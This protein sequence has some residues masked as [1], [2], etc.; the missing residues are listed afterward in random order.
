MFNRR[1][2]QN[3]SVYHGTL[4]C[5]TEMRARSDCLGDDVLSI[6]FQNLNV[7]DLL[8][9]EK[10]CKKWSYAFESSVLG[11]RF[12]Q[13]MKKSSA[14]W[15]RA[16]HKMAMDET[17]LKPEDYK[18][19]C[20]FI[21]H[22]IQQVDDNW[23]KGKFKLTSCPNPNFLNRRFAIGEDFITACDEK[24]QQT[25]IFEK[26][27]MELK[28]K[29][30]PDTSEYQILD[31]NT[32][33]YCHSNEL[34]FHDTK[35]NELL[36]WIGLE[37]GPFRLL[38]CS[39]IKLFALC[40]NVNCMEFRVDIWKVDNVSDVTHVKAIE[41]A[42]QGTNTS[43]Y[44]W[45][46]D[47]QF[48]HFNHYTFNHPKHKITTCHFISTGIVFSSG[49]ERSLSVIRRFAYDQGL[50][51]IISDQLIRILDVASGTYLHDIHMNKFRWI[52]DIRVNSNYVV[53]IGRVNLYVYSLKALKN[54]RP[55]DPFVSK[56]KFKYE[57]L[58]ALVDETQIVCLGRNYTNN[59]LSDII[60]IDF[61]SFDQ[62][63]VP[64]MTAP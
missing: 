4:L 37:Q 47:E 36:S 7:H 15:R 51:F 26:E 1:S 12:F 43:C 20:R 62:M 17:N 45:K 23:R 28:R 58:D 34:A 3:F 39:A 48:F 49:L 6:I 18:N 59:L 25:H 32:V 63:S 57:T 64:I 27:S 8:S 33:V 38:D 40:S 14:A 61:G 52:K 50:M 55:T 31:M 54:A 2:G 10:V 11:R 41:M 24:Y 9:C 5:T 44:N 56:I 30:I 46:V 16:W 53:I 21:L 42:W 13:R 29:F 60:V 22:Y 35:T 19:I